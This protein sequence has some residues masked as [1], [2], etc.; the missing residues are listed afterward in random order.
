MGWEKD[1]LCGD[2]GQAIG[3]GGRA[4]DLELGLLGSNLLE[5]IT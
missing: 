3:G 2:M 5:L 4:G 1:E